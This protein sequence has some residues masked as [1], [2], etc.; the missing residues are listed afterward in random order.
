[1]FGPALKPA[2]IAIKKRKGLDLRKLLATH[3]MMNSFEYVVEGNTL[4]VGSSY[5]VPGT[6]KPLCEIHEDGTGHVPSR[7]MLKH[8][9]VK[10]EENIEKTLE[11]KL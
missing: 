4:G 7:P 11:G 3:D 5:T 6:T 9:I 8:I 1:M 10:E 2:T